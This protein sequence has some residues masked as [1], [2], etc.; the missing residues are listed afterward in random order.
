MNHEREK[1][2]MQEGNNEWKRE[3]K[4]RRNEEIKEELRNKEITKGRDNIIQK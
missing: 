1:D 2:K 3:V 4:K